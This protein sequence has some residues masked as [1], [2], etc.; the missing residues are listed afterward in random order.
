MQSA[1]L[2]SPHCS[3][4]PVLHARKAFGA[5]ALITSL[6]SALMEGSQML[7]GL[8]LRASVFAD[9]VL[10]GRI[11]QLVLLVPTA[12]VGTLPPARSA[13]FKMRSA[14][15]RVNLLMTATASPGAPAQYI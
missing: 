12:R 1:T 8:V 6:G 10:E 2:V 3:T 13:P 15:W 14:L 4:V 7:L 11:A 5:L 9:L